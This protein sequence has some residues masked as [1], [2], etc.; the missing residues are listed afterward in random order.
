VSE[1]EKTEAQ[2]LIFAEPEHDAHYEQWVHL[3]CR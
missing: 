1:R 2:G 3:L